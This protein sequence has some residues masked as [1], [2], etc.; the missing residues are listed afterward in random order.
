[1]LVQRGKDLTNVET[2]IGTGGPIIFCLNPEE[3]LSYTLF[4]DRNPHNLKP[5]HPAFHIDSKYILYAM[6][7]LA[8]VDPAKALAIMKKYIVGV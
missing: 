7:L 4:D 1:M 3:V 6:G 5:K 2:V 8:K